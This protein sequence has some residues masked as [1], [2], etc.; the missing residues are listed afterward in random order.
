MA[1]SQKLPTF[2]AH[3]HG[4]HV[5]KKCESIGTQALSYQYFRELQKVFLA[6]N[7]GG[8]LP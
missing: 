6:C 1:F 8:Y 4:D 7:T 5:Q 3:T 2:Q